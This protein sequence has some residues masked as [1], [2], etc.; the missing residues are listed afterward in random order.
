MG[1]QGSGKT[2]YAMLVA[3]EVYGNWSDVLGHLYF[4]PMES[5]PRLR[6]ALETGSRVP[7]II[8]DDAGLHLS[9][10]LLSTGKRGWRIAVLFNGL[11][12]LA[13]TVTAA[14]IY[15]S[16]D[17]DILK[18]LRKK[19]WIIA[20]PMAPHGAS[21][22]ERA[23]YLYRKRILASGRPIAKKIGI[24]FYRLDSI[25]DWVR[26]HYEAKR[27]EAMKPLMEQLNAIVKGGGEDE[28]A[29]PQS[30]EATEEGEIELEI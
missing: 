6:E 22:P 23:A 5:L 27:R 29:P 2:T 20:E 4:D 24:D 15:T 11:I 7:L 12:N 18:E 17:M 26:K 3:Y 19:A 14:L 1:P 21:R 30:H 25:P 9:K 28:E 16:P 8:Y 13:R 10:Y